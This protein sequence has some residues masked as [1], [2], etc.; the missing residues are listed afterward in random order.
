MEEMAG[1]RPLDGRRLRATGRTV[2]LN[3]KVTEETKARF[4][5]LAA[6]RGVMMSELFEEAVALLEKDAGR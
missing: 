2:Q 3:L 5:A 1:P 6:A 4:L